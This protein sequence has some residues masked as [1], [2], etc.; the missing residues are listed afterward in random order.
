MNKF[1]LKIPALLLVLLVNSMFS[2]ER[3]DTIL[4]QN[5]DIISGKVIQLTDDDLIVKESEKVVQEFKIDRERIFSYTDASGEHV[6]YAYDT[7]IGN[8]FTIEEMRY[9]IRGEQDGR[10]G[11][12]ARPA[13]YTNLVIGAAGGITG[14]FFFPIPA[15]AFAILVGIPKVK[16]KKSTIRNLDD[17]NHP[18][19]IMGYERM[20]RRNRKIQALVGG[21]IGL[22]AGLGTF[23]ILQASDKELIK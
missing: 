13:F 3:K 15:F 18:P 11:F 14:S 10:K 6:L 5:G 1:F 4:L 16:I 12:K 23:L 9:F 2:Q 21:G 8:D 20:A 19:Y 7:L 22:V 17:L